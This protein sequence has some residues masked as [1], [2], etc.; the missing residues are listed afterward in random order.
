MADALD[1]STD[2][3]H[4]LKQGLLSYSKHIVKPYVILICHFLKSIAL[5][6]K[7]IPFPLRKKMFIGKGSSNQIFA[8]H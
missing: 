6:K 2:E 4:E 7:Q 5:N 1:R 3:Y 8:Y